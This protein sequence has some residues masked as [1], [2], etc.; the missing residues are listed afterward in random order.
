MKVARVLLDR[1]IF[2]HALQ[3]RAMTRQTVPRAAGPNHAVPY[4]C[5]LPI[6]EPESK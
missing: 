3:C 1:A 4:L 6:I 2:V 5:I